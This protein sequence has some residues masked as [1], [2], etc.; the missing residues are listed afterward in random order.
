VS[1]EATSARER[2]LEA[3][4]DLFSRQGYEQTSIEQVLDAAGASRGA[5]YHHFSGKQELFEA[6]LATVEQTVAEAVASAARDARTPAEAFRAG[7]GKYLELA[8]NPTVR[9]ICLIDAPVAL[10]WE[11][12]REIGARYGLGLMRAAVSSDREASDR[13]DADARTYLAQVLLASV[14]EL[15]LL[16]GQAEEPARARRA[17]MMTFELLVGQVETATRER[18][19]IGEAARCDV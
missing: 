17:A 3:A 7:G 1:A 14:M 10:G 15:A 9:R 12:W 19:A 6:V 18:S 11:R 2:V 8:E 16:I 13:V 4:Q 5:L